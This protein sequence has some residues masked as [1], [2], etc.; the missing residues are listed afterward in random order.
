MLGVS[1]DSGGAHIFTYAYMCHVS[2]TCMA[3]LNAIVRIR[4]RMPQWR[5]TG[6]S[7]QAH[8]LAQAEHP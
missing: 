7:M 3:S 4:Y 8:V 5:A 6:D 1:R 2:H